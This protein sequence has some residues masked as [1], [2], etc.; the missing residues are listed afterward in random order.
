MTPLPTDIL[1]RGILIQNGEVL[2]LHRTPEKG[3][4][5]NL[6][7]G[8]VEANESPGEG[9]LRE[10]KEEIGVYVKPTD[11]ELIRVVYRDKRVSSPKLHLVFWVSNWDGIPTNC[12]PT[13][14]LGVN[15]FPLD[16]LPPNL[17][18]V[19]GIVLRA[20]NEDPFYIESRGKLL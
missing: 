8:K 7:G 10:I 4:G 15:W 11:I 19:A 9:L 5:Y 12:E 17:A 2:L 13:K 20:S 6:V 14:C 3:G 1:V 18:T 16:Q